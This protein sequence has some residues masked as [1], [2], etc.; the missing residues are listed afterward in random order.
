[1]SQPWPLQPYKFKTTNMV[2]QPPSEFR[3]T[4]H[5]LYLGSTLPTAIFKGSVQLK[6]SSSSVYRQVWAF[7][8]GVGPILS[9]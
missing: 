4:F 6:L 5:I 7:D 3:F 2:R 9:F 1:M 8:C